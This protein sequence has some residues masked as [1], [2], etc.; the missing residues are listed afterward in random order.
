MHNKQALIWQT[1]TAKPTGSQADRRTERETHKTLGW[2][3]NIDAIQTG[4]LL[5]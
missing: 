1:G 2:A 5:C 3:E 4:H